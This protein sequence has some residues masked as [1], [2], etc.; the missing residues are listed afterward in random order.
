MATAV[1]STRESE[2][3]APGRLWWAGPLAILASVGANV[4]TRYIAGMFLAIPPEF[5]PLH[6]R[7]I[8]LL[9]AGGVT[10]AVLTF[11]AVSRLARRPL[12][13]FRRVSVVALVLSFVPDIGLMVS[14][15][16][17]GTTG[18]TVSLLMLLHVV[19]AVVSVGILTRLA[20]D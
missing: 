12:Q 3:V 20:R 5:E 17:P 8:I 11:A 10:G 9:T 1:I 18:M 6:Y 15:A 14:Q 2:R 4:A 19:A 16:M 7:D 13:L